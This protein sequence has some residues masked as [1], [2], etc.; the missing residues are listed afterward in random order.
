MVAEMQEVP[1]FPA[2]PNLEQNV[3]S[4]RWSIHTYQQKKNTVLISD[5]VAN[6]LN[7]QR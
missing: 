3:F 6:Q 7:S 5:H 4:K 1:P 2:I